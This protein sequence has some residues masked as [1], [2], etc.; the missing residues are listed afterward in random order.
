M[1]IRN[2]QPLVC[3]VLCCFCGLCPGLTGGVAR[4]ADLEVS[5]VTFTGVID[6]FIRQYTATFYLDDVELR[7][8]A[9][10][11]RG[12]VGVEYTIDTF[13]GLAN[14]KVGVALSR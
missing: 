12:T 1:E 9:G 6:P 11:L 5:N 8:K 3:W 10:I 7:Q 2:S 4:G 13:V 14:F